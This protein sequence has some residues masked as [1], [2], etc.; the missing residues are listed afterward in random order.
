MR[1]AGGW[2]ISAGN[3][4]LE[5]DKKTGC[6]SSLVITQGKQF[7]W[8]AHPGDVTVR[9]DLIRKTFDHRDLNR[10]D[11]TEGKDSLTIEK[12]FDGAPWLLRETYGFEEEAISWKSQVILDAGEFRSCAVSYNIPWPQPMYPISFWAAKDN[13]PTA[14]HMFAEIAL[15]YGE[16]TSGTTMPALCS[17]LEEQNTGLLLTM[18]FDFITPRFSFVSAYREPNLRAQ[19]DWMALSHSRSAQTSLLLRGTTGDWRS[20]LGWLYERFKEYFE[21][22]SNIIDNLWGGHISGRWNVSLEEAKAMAR[23]GLK[24]HEIHRHFP[25]YG[26]YHPEGVESWRSGHDRDDDALITI[27]AIRRTIENLHAVGAA[28]MPYIQVT[29][30]GDETLLDPAFIGSRVQD[31]YGNNTSAWPCTLLMNSD[32]SLPFGKDMT[33]QIN[34]LVS[35][36]PEMDGVFLDQP[37]YN[38]QDTAHDDGITAV[39]NQ[40]AYM[41]GLNYYPHLEHLSSLLHPDKAIMANAPYGVGIFKY[42]DGFMAEGEGWLCDRLQ[43]YGLAK[44]MFFLVYQSGDADIELM[45][46]SCLVH[47]A[48][49]TSYSE[50]AASA[51]LYD[52]YVPLVEKLFRRKWVF[53]PKPISFPKMYKGGIFRSR[54]GSLLASIVGSN[55]RLPGRPIQDRTVSVS[56]SDVERVS[57]ITLYQPGGKSV[58]LPFHKENGSVQFDVPCDTVAAVAELKIGC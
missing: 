22:R 27:D 55:T 8:S 35:R 34:G 7:T 33:R 43:Y 4:T 40:P 19:F 13:M 37:C 57:S 17:Y 9:D 54:S 47:G 42:I 36:Y 5:I 11:F 31:Y 14:P 39:N 1:T 29:G 2:Q 32:P 6:M 48:G 56:T 53:D 24:W 3:L 58:E 16:A 21:P 18:P 51:D 52:M 45:F 50:A 49:Y 25:A 12:V 15:E 38:H 30:D 20:A 23:L 44:P 26:N 10:V 46:Q 41:T 28:A